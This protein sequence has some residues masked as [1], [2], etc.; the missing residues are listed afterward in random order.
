[1]T[2]LRSDFTVE[3]GLKLYDEPARKMGKKVV[4]KVCENI[5][6]IE[7]NPD[8][9]GVDLIGY[10]KD[11][12]IVAYIEV[13]CSQSWVG[14]KFP[15]TNLSFLGRKNKYLTDKKYQGAEFYFVM[16]NQDFTSFAIT[17]R[18]YILK[19]PLK[20]RYADFQGVE[21]V[22]WIPEPDFSWFIIRLLK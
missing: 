17:S 18:N 10:D 14:E 16:F 6:V 5:S 4:P 12:N 11:G 21:K 3:E 19:R 8:P 15:W 1:M 22:R 9:Y 2:H 20:P 7:D 13:E